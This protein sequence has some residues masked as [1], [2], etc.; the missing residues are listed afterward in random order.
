M[1]IGAWMVAM[2]LGIAISLACA[3]GGGSDAPTTDAE[4]DEDHAPPQVRVVP[5]EVLSATSGAK[6]AAAR[7]KAPAR[8]RGA[9]VG[10]AAR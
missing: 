9:K 2:G 6:A 7:Q 8:R 5:L 3:G 1:R 10:K 4:P